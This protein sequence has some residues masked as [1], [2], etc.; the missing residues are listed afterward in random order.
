GSFAHT[1]LRGGYAYF[2][3]PADEEQVVIL[4]ASGHGM[5]YV[6][7]EP[8]VGDPYSTGYVR[9]PVLLKKGTNDLLFH[10]SRGTLRAKL[11][12]PKGIVILDG[13]DV[14]LPDFI[15]GKEGFQWG[16]LVAINAT[17]SEMA[18]LKVEVASGDS[19]PT[20]TPLPVLAPLSTR[21]IAFR[22]HGPPS[23]QKG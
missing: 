12:V 7:G 4:E 5:V 14:T 19:E 2:A 9:L 21:K 23:A 15:T 8:R 13:G 18:D 20:A 3:V 10:V 22:V 6:N 16:S 11:S 17:T 1:A